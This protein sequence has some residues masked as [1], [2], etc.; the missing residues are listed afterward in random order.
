MA[1]YPKFEKATDNVIRII[2]EKVDE[3]PLT[4]LLEN[5]KMLEEKIAQMQGVLK[6]IN[7]IIENA[8]QLGIVPEEKDNPEKKEG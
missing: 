2:S 8:E 7:E 1:D 3:V 5:K 4:K 6:N